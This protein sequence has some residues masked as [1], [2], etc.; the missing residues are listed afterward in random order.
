MKKLISTIVA[1]FLVVI[2]IEAQ[3]K[4]E[5]K[6]MKKEMAET[7]YL[8]T[9]DLINTNSFSYVA[10][11]TIPIGGA[12]IF[13]NTIPNYLNIEGEQADIYL[14]YFGT[15]QAGN[16]YSPEAGIK[17]KGTVENYRVEFDDKKQMIRIFFEVQRPKERHE[18]TF[19]VFKDGFA[20]LVV[21]SNR[22]NSITY[23]GLFKE[24]DMVLTN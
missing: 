22:R 21:A 8:A 19:N 11:E 6:Q 14:P 3:T 10:E 1:V 4:E 24:L 2:A 18:F 23:N 15:L 9:K 7:Q 13:L 5:K 17:F 16:G 20:R 12:R